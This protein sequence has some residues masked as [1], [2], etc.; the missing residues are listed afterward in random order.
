MTNDIVGKGML[1]KAFEKSLSNECIFFCSGVS[2]SQE[3]DITQF[4]RE[5]FLLNKYLSNRKKIFVYFSSVLASK[6]NTPYLLHKKRMEDIISK[7]SK[8]FIILRLPQVVGESLNNTLL[9]GLIKSILRNEVINVYSNAMRNLID[10]EDVVRIFDLLY[11]HK[12]KN[13]TVDICAKYDIQP[14]ILVNLIA[15]ELFKS[16]NLVEINKESLQICDFTFLNNYLDKNDHLR[17]HNYADSVAKKYI[18]KI[19]DMAIKGNN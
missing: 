18:K 19:A 10:V 17:N 2:N 4:N 13:M 12:I 8:N 1:A 3:T 9:P 7:K 6:P 16:V 15:N 5:E 11:K 14:I